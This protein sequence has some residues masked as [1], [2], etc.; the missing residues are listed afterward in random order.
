M[1]YKRKTR[2]TWQLW[3][4]YGSSHGWEHELTELT[5]KA[6]QEQERTYALNAPQY[7]TAIIVARERLEE[8]PTA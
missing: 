3:V 2:D 6:I 7:P 5:F 8:E 4:N 1:T